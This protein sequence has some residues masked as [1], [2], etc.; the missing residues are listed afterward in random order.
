M[1]GAAE[2][3]GTAEEAAGMAAMVGMAAVVAGMMA[4]AA[5]GMAMAGMVGTAGGV[6]MNTT[7]NGAAATDVSACPLPSPVGSAKRQYSLLASSQACR[8]ND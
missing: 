7:E 2:V 6:G 1:D 3:A 4:M 5:H 8:I